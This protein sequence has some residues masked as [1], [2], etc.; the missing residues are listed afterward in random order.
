[1]FVYL[2]L[3]WIHAVLTFPLRLFTACE[4]AGGGGI[5]REFLSFP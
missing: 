1:M 3:S 4:G 5:V 2:L